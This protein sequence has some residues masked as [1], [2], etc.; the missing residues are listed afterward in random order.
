MTLTHG[1]SAQKI[2]GDL[3]PRLNP[4]VSQE[5]PP[6]F[7]ELTVTSEHYK[8][9]QIV[10]SFWSRVDRKGP[11]PEHTPEL[12]ECWIW[13]GAL[14]PKQRGYFAIQDRMRKSYHVSWLLAYGY[15][16]TKEI[17]HLCH[18]TRCV[19]VT[20]LRDVTHKEN[21][22]NRTCSQICHRGHPLKDPNL[23]YYK[24]NGETKRRCLACITRDREEQKRKRAEARAT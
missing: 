12:G 13:E 8:F 23:Y 3:L 22:N 16:P 21:I 24:S 10:A 7:T 11:I 15:W 20:H 18:N 14:T 17:D 4:W 5:A 9:D 6:L 2:R 19:R 1:R